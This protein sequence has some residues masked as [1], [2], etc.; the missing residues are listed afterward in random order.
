MREQ[1]ALSL[2]HMEVGMDK[3]SGIVPGTARV[4]S[5]DMKDAAPIRPGTPGF[6]RPQGISTLKDQKN[7]AEVLQRSRQAHD[8]LMASRHRDDGKAALAK[9]ISDKFFMKNNREA[10][11]V[12]DIEP[13]KNLPMP[14]Y[15]VDS[16][17]Y[18]TE[19]DLVKTPGPAPVEGVLYPKGSFIDY[20]A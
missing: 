11:P 3:I 6:G 15:T 20:E 17:R 10:S 8:E 18:T 2:R 13:I 14:S 4:T 12:V 5:V 16:E 9:D 19:N 1:N 7:L